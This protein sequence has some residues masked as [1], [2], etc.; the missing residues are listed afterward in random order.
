MIK[1]ERCGGR[2][3]WGQNMNK[4][5]Q[6]SCAIHLWGRGIIKKIKKKKAERPKYACI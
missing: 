1:E 2:E 4:K 6:N 5:I 3:V